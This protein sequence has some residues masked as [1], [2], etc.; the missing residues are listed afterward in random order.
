MNLWE[1]FGFYCAQTNKP[2]SH[3]F[4]LVVFAITELYIQHLCARTENQKLRKTDFMLKLHI[5]TSSK[6]LEVI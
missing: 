3:F 2:K 4:L 6:F 5:T 1:N